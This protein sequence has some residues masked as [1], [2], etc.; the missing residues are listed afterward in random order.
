MSALF[1]SQ[2][3]NAQ[4]AESSDILPNPSAA[5][6]GVPNFS[7][8]FRI[9]PS[10]SA[11]FGTVPKSSERTTNHTLTVREVA[12]M[13]EDSKVSRTERSIVNWCLPNRHNV[14]RLDGVYDVNERKWFI[15]HESVERAIAEE[16][17]RAARQ[18]EPVPNASEMFRKDS[19]AEV[20]NIPE[21]DDPQGK[22]KS[23]YDGDGEVTELNAK[24]RDLENANRVKDAVIKNLEANLRGADEERRG[25]INQLIDKSYHIGSLESQLLRLSAPDNQTHRALP[26]GREP[27]QR[28]PQSADGLVN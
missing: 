25:Y 15:T 22:G 10:G 16:Q 23:S 21:T 1:Q 26:N 8:T 3:N 9:V 24:L 20:P 12:R 6:G 27:E 7:E 14:S 2:H 28:F 11:S 19:N 5:F 13:F 17:A 4:G 18:N